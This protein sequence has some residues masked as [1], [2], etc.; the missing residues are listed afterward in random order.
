MI[1]KKNYQLITN[2]KS[3]FQRYGIINQVIGKGAYGLIK[4]IDPDTSSS[5][6]TTTTTTGSPKF[7]MNRNLYAVKQWFRK[8]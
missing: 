3:L 1:I 5:S 8:K 2:E 7:D 4:I 6:S